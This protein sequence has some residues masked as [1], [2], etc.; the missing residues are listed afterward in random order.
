MS[1]LSMIFSLGF[2]FVACSV[3]AQ[4][5]SNIGLLNDDGTGA[6]MTIGSWMVK[7]RL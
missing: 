6:W 5:Q 4:P 2:S 3:S 7:L 1:K